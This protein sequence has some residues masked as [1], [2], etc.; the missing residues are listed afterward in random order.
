MK[1]WPLSASYRSR[2]EQGQRSWRQYEKDCCSSPVPLGP[3]RKP[4]LRH[5]ALQSSTR[6]IG[7]RS[8]VYHLVGIGRHE[9]RQFQE[10]PGHCSG[11]FRECLCRRYPQQPDSKIHL[12]GH[13]CHHMGNV[14]FGKRRVQSAVGCECRSP[15]KCLCGGQREQP[16]PEILSGRGIHHCMGHSGLSCRAVCNTLVSRRGSP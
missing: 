5:V 7:R 4:D 9:Q 2:Q 11:H 16:H 13:L 1:Q 14:R 10:A 8:H 3:V 15:G 12:Y 6:G